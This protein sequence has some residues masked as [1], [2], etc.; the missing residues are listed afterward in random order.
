[1]SEKDGKTNSKNLSRRDFLRNTGILAGGAVLGTGLLAGCSEGA[2]KDTPA[3]A[4][5]AWDYEA[6]VIVCGTGPAGLACAAAAA[7]AGVSVI[8]IDS[9]D[10]IG[11]KGILA[12]G[13]LGIGGGTR[14]QIAAGFE[15]TAE[16]IYEDRTVPNL[17]TDKTMVVETVD[18]REVEMGQWRKIS[19]A[20]DGEGM[21]RAF[22]DNSLDTWNWLDIMGVPFI[23]ANVSQMAAVYRGSRYYTTTSPRLV[24][25]ENG[26]D[27]DMQAGGA[28]LCWP[29]YD[30]AVDNGAQFIL[31]CKMTKILRAEGDRAG[32]VIGIEATLDGKT[33]RM[34]GNKAVFL[35]TGSW[36]GSTK[37]K[38]LFLPWL[39]KYPH[40]SGEPYV[41][42]DGNGIE[43]ALDAGASLSTDR[44][45]DWHGWH[46]HPGTLWHSIKMPFG[47]PGTAEPLDSECIYV[48]A[49]GKR[50]MNE[51]IGEDNP[52]WVGGSK[53]FYFAQL[54]AAQTTDKDGPVVWI[55]LDE[56]SRAKQ[57]LKFIVGETVEDFMYG[58]ADTLEEL[59]AAIKVPADALVAS[60]T[61]YNELVDKGADEDFAKRH[62]N[63]KIAAPP[64][65]AVKWGIQK[66][67]TLGGVT[68]NAKAQVVDWDLE[69]IPGLY[70]AGESAGNMDLIGLAKPIVFGRIAGM[71]IA[72]EE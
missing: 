11:G 57:E 18:G 17:R 42:N 21:A 1:M 13:N 67:N 43:A 47:L 12:G 32:R 30:T 50:F 5:E 25:R 52:A 14:M 61:R 63:A 9:N 8:A 36:K 19:G 60:V 72:H 29:I 41:W 56:A 55:I 53:P 62:L 2:A 45:S 69:P 37:L 51:E 39:T 3:P 15:E 23:K 28:G 44:G 70:A 40:I 7:E 68:I 26:K 59:A 4:G 49:E 71:T 46:R 27:G 65:H 38:Q 64:F 58:T 54:C 6:D 34:K 24:D 33:V 16:I 48:N 31:S 20:E 66:H 10:K 22:A 35:G